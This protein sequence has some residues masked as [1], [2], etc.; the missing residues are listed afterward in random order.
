MR[1]FYHNNQTRFK[2]L[3]AACGRDLRIER[4]KQKKQNMESN[5]R[6]EPRT[7]NA[8]LR[9]VHNIPELL[10]S[11]NVAENVAQDEINRKRFRYR[12]TY[13]MTNII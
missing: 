7:E 6:P 12:I 9:A 3:C 10:I 5:I 13:N 11:S 8:N 1:H 2:D 4:E